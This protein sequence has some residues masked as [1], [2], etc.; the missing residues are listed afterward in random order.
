M[1]SPKA[2]QKD[3]IDLANALGVKRSNIDS[4]R[5]KLKHSEAYAAYKNEKYKEYFK[6]SLLSLQAKI[7]HPNQFLFLAHSLYINLLGGKRKK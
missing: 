6:A 5:A 2:L 1:N 3:V 7:Y 4:Y